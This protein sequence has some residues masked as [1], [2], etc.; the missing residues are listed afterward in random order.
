MKTLGMSIAM[1]RDIC[2]SEFSEK[3]NEQELRNIQKIVGG[4]K[5]WFVVSLQSR[6]QTNHGS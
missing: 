1:S 5:K 3:Y 6:M 4:F 2:V